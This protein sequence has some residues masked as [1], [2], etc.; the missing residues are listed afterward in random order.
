M[1][2]QRD[3]YEIS[4]D[5]ARLDRRAIWHFLRTSYWW[6]DEVPRA[7]VEKAID[8]SPLVFGLYDSTGS[9]AG[10]ARVVTD[11]CRFAWLADVF[12]LEPHRGGGLGVWRSRLRSTIPSWNASA[13][14]WAPPSARTVRAVRVSCGR[15]RADDG[16]PSTVGPPVRPFRLARLHVGQVQ[17]TGHPVDFTS[18]GA[19]MTSRIAAMSSAT[20]G[21]P[22]C[23]RSASSLCHSSTNTKLVLALAVL[24]D[25]VADAAGLLP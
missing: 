25:P 19:T 18:G 15:R 13:S 6:P 3:G 9:Q 10:F 11:R 2:W 17:R 1:E 16:T 8:N 7:A 4:P 22:K 24:V 14:C 20:W 21:V 5:P 23:C 12:V